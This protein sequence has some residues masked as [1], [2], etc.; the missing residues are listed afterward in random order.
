MDSID[1]PSPPPST[2]LAPGQRLSSS[3]RLRL[4][5]AGGCR[6]RVSLHAEQCRASGAERNRYLV[7]RPPLPGGD[8]GDGR[9]LLARA[10]LDPALRRRRA[11]RANSRGPGLRRTPL[12][13]CLAG[14]VDRL[15]ASLFTVPVF[16]ALALERQ[17]RSS[18]RSAFRRTRWISRSQYW[19][20]RMLGAP[21]GIALY[22]VLGFFNGIGRPTITLRITLALR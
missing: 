13:A 5:Y 6:T 4:D 8:L 7:R 12:C 16:A 17:R 11:V 9:G 15:W 14:H 1:A 10:G 20:P 18:R 19:F 22:S 3:G 21:L 2:E